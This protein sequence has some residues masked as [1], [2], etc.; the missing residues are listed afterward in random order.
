MTDQPMTAI[1]ALRAFALQHV[2]D[3]AAQALIDQATHELTGRTVVWPEDDAVPL[4]FFFRRNEDVTG[5][6]GEGHIAD[7]VLW[8]DGT[9]SLRWRG[10]HPKID[11]CDRGIDTAEF[12]HG[13]GGSTQIVFIDQPGDI[14]AIGE[15]AAAPL[16]LRR[17][18]EHAL[19]KPVPC[20]NCSR[21]VACRCIADRTEARV[22]V[23]LGALAPW[24]KTGSGEAA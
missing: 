21:T 19:R 15:P 22:D 14:P 20:P 9:V 12:V 4:R 10:P 16:V 7:G 5:I 24:L 17:V 13:H 1:A 3:A 8:P 2:D 23:V 11:F 6:S 18:L